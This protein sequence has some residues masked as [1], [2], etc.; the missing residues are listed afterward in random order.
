MQVAL[1]VRT[2]D[3]AATEEVLVAAPGVTLQ[4][5]S[6][7]VADVTGELLMGC[8][9]AVVLVVDPVIKV[10]QI[11]RFTLKIKLIEGKQ[12]PAYSERML[13]GQITPPEQ[14]K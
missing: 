10:D 5:K 8:R 9:T 4:V 1:L 7:E 14:K 2:V 13:V 3:P 11:S 12:V 6:D